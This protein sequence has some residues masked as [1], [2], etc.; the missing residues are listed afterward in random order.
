M[1]QKKHHD[2]PISTYITKPEEGLETA[3]DRIEGLPSHMTNLFSEFRE[4]VS[5]IGEDFTAFN[6]KLESMRK[7]LISIYYDKTLNGMKADKLKESFARTGGKEDGHKTIDP[8]HQAIPSKRN[9]KKE[10]PQK[11]EQKGKPHNK[12][13]HLTDKH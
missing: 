9:K 1:Q 13:G 10:E 12:F 6:L 11:Q 2:K 3:R 5:D 4:F 7:A 8:T